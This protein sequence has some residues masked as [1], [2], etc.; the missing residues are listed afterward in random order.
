V[1]LGYLNCTLWPTDNRTFI[2]SFGAP[3]SDSELR[4]LHHERA[5]MAAARSLPAFVPWL[6]PACA[7][8]IGRVEAMGELRNKWRRFVVDGAPV[9]LGLHVVGDALCHT[10]PSHAKG[11]SLAFAHAVA[12]ANAV[13]TAPF[14][15]VQRALMLDR[16]LCAE[17]LQT[18]EFSVAA[19]RAS[20]RTWRGEPPT[21]EEA[22]GFIKSVIAPAA[23]VDPVVFRAY[24]RHFH[25]LS[26]ANELLGDAEVVERARRVASTQQGYGAVPQ[27][28]AGPSRSALLT[29]LA[30]LQSPSGTAARGTADDQPAAAPTIA[31]TI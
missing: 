18:F 28:P 3:A 9:A 14:D 15:P 2:V 24:Q 26:P 6:D 30:S 27:P 10:N 21:A 29:L 7:E 5:F 11:A 8:P 17:T 13:D 25:V 1:G 12:L 22:H 19:D 4:A 23:K 31:A 20:V 16:T